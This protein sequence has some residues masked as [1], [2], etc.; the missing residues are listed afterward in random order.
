VANG[1]KD[2][3]ARFQRNELNFLT[4]KTAKMGAEAIKVPAS[5]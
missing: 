4:G 5:A 1:V 3:A 2:D